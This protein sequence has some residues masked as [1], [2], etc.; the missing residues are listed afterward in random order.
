[1]RSRIVLNV[2]IELQIA[3][4]KYSLDEKK[5]KATLAMLQEI[6]DRLSLN[7]RL[8]AAGMSLY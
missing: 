5:R 1:M 3:L 8:L 2:Y 6:W 7:D 4:K